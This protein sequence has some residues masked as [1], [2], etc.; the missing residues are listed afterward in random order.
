VTGADGGAV[1]RVLLDSP[2]FLNGS[3]AA[4]PS[5]STITSR[6]WVA[7]HL[8][9][10]AT[11]AF[12]QPTAALT[13]LWSEG[14]PGLRVAGSYLLAQDLVGADGSHALVDC[15]LTVQADAVLAVEL[16]WP[17][18]HQD[19]DLH[20]LRQQVDGGVLPDSP[21]DCSFANC[22]PQQTPLAWGNA[23][24][25]TTGPVLAALS[26]QGYG[27]ERVELSVP[28]PGTYVVQVHH[29]DDQ[30][31]GPT[32]G[33]V[34]L[35]LR[36]HAVAF[37]TTSSLAV[38]QRVDVARVVVPAA[39]DQPIC[40]EDLLTP[41]S[42]CFPATTTACMPGQACGLG[43]T[44]SPSSGA[45]EAHVT[46]CTASSCG[47]GRA[48]QAATQAC[49]EAQCNAQLACPL[50]QQCQLEQLR[51]Q[52]LP[53][54]CSDTNEPNNDSA[55]ATALTVNAAQHT[56]HIAAAPLCRGDVDVFSFP[57]TSDARVQVTLTVPAASPLL[58][59]DLLA[60]DGTTILDSRSAEST[61]T[62]L[63]AYFSSGTQGYVRL[64]LDTTAGLDQAD[65]TLDAVMT[66]LPSCGA[67]PG[68]PN[69]TLATASA[70]TG[71]TT[72]QLVCSATDED[73][74]RFTP[75]TNRRVTFTLTAPDALTAELLTT[76]GIP[77]ALQQTGTRMDLTA[78][79]GAATEDWILHVAPSDPLQAFPVAYVV[80]LTTAAPPTCADSAQE[81]NG[82][83]G[84]AFPIT[85]API[86][87][88]ACDALDDD[89]YAFT[90]TAAADVDVLLQWQ[91]ATADLDLYVIAL[92]GT[93][94]D[95]AATGDNPEAVL[96]L[97]LE[98]GTYVV[99]VQPAS[100]GAA[101]V[102]YTLDFMG[103]P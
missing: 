67:E 20:L 37:I 49:V 61:T 31:A 68:E 14:H 35:S 55:H 43:G 94:L 86:S 2:V 82:T 46:P 11:L 47:A 48:C 65:C 29:F 77:L 79:T 102:P 87:G 83:L 95:T 13:E 90:V 59:A 5:G 74:L 66:V 23:D 36:G 15:V 103:W 51:C 91:D 84:G 50:P 12:L 69:D 19:L 42:M 25:G 62:L 57:V 93:S 64:R 21:E 56:A 63:T 71:T 101:A 76:T 97:H 80:D 70:V 28:P 99:R 75:P 1:N 92:D 27:P 32:E 53:P 89:F 54:V 16:T 41:G 3:S 60:P 85:T 7:Q 34:T 81:P 9:S 22:T 73:F 33:T 17:T 45:C 10:G 40:V 98:P 100:I 26:D 38:D 72:S 88:V 96:A 18:A 24:A 78:A 39:A 58:Q 8:P 6:A 44:C 52:G 30:A 4:L